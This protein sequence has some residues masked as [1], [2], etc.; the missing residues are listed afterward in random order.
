[1]KKVAI[2]LATYNG[3][4][5]LEEQLHSLLR[6][7]YQP[8]V[9]VVSDDNSTDGTWDILERW[10]SLYPSLF[11]LHLNSSGRH[12]HAANFS[13]L[14][15]LG[16]TSECDYF[17]FC[18]Q[19][20][21]WL[22]NKI[23][24]QLSACLAEEK[25]YGSSEPILV[26]SDLKVVDSSLN[27]IAAS[28]FNF[29]GL[30]GAQTHDFPKF[31]IQNNVTGCAT[32][33]NRALLEVG[34]PLPKEVVV[35]DWWFALVAKLLGRLVFIDQSLIAYRQHSENAIGAKV[36]K[37]GISFDMLKKL[38]GLKKH[39]VKSANQASRLLELTGVG[40]NKNVHPNN[41]VLLQFAALAEQSA[42]TRWKLSSHFVN[43][44]NSPIERLVFAL[45]FLSIR[46][47]SLI[48][49]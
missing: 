8:Y 20:D 1:M 12:G 26:H 19:D 11:E 29:Q 30:P 2:L 32:L 49:K 44:L 35:H 37:E 10:S 33:I 4:V 38:W 22:D 39:I 23:K 31:L 34:S 43:N 16:K 46:K 3:E 41:K 25:K 24:T 5:F 47:S 6:Q 21:V 48:N 13:N 7:T 42:L 14:C 15:E 17:L 27:E 36:I 28:F 40:A 45:L 18:D 9:V